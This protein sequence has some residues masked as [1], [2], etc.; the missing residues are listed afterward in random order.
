VYLSSTPSRSLPGWEAGEVGVEEA[1]LPWRWMRAN[2][3]IIK[4][5][6]ETYKAFVMLIL[7]LFLSKKK[8]KGKGTNKRT[9]LSH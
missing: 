7:F 9:D 4:S 1:L 5:K 6:L 3:H 2:G 8:K